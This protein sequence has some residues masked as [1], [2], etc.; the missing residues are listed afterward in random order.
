MRT[1]TRAALSA[2]V[3]VFLAS[4]SWSAP[5][6]IL[7]LEIESNGS[8]G[9]LYIDGMSTN[10]TSNW[11]WGNDYRF[12]QREKLVIGL[13]RAGYAGKTP[14]TRYR[15][16]FGGT[17]E[18]LPPPYN[19]FPD[20]TI[21]GSTLRLR[22][23][24]TDEVWA[25]DAIG[26]ATIEDGLYISSGVTSKVAT[27]TTVTNNSTLSSPNIVANWARRGFRVE[28][29]PYMELRAVAF[30]Q[31]ADDRKPVAGVEFRATDGTSSYSN[32]VTT[33]ERVSSPIWSDMPVIQAYVARFGT[34]LFANKSK[35]RVN[36]RAYALEGTNYFDTETSGWIEPSPFPTQ[37]TNFVNW[38]RTRAVVSDTGVNA[39]GVAANEEFWATNSAPAD[40]LNIGAAWLAIQG[41]NGSSYGFTN[42][43]GG[44]IYLKGLTTYLGN[45]VSG[46]SMD[47]EV[48]IT[49]HW[50]TPRDQAGIT[51]YAVDRLVNSSGGDVVRIKDCT[52]DTS[53]A[54][55]F[56]SDLRCLTMDQVYWK[57]STG[58]RVF[59]GGTVYH[60]TDCE[61]SNTYGG[62]RAYS[63][64]ANCFGLVA[65]NRIV[66]DAKALVFYTALG[67][68]KVSTNAFAVSDY[69]AATNMARGGP[70]ILAYNRF[71]SQDVS[72]LD[73]GTQQLNPCT[74]GMAVVQNELYE[75]AG[76][77]PAT[78]GAALF[79]T[80]DVASTN[81]MFWANRAGVAKLNTGY[82]NIGTNANP[83]VQWQVLN[84]I[85]DSMPIK[86][87]AF[88][89]ASAGRTGNRTVMHGVNWSG[90]MHIM[91]TNIA[92]FSDQLFPGIFTSFGKDSPTNWAK[93]TRMGGWDGVSWN[94]PFG[95]YRLR[96]SSPV[97]P[98]V[99]VLRQPLPYD[100]AGVPRGRA[101]PPGA[102]AN[103][104][105]RTTALMAQ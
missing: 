72:F 22:F 104:P 64:D 87:W 47:G 94:P 40:F 44:I 88:G 84:G 59:G 25:G 50:N 70:R 31:S 36:F 21:S 17:N 86:G 83:R 4:Q 23:G 103:T 92:D 89:T 56:S 7:G 55:L 93:W 100:L 102:Y 57:N 77:S 60:V 5:G 51:N 67:N 11:G 68:Y 28:D 99:R 97:L 30:H 58:A 41:T 49:R 90:N 29:G 76:T 42:A 10:G 33:M 38:P 12:S 15:T 35:V 69:G 18:T 95:N 80:D 8:F 98:R 96:S 65:G 101:D 1:L 24:L 48:L 52:L 91:T 27:L 61:V 9:A 54:L 26:F 85:Y 32:L 2:L 105:R 14:T 39:S 3:S 43:T 79:Q 75:F 13:S 6:D 74:F 16:I 34:N 71:P 46:N 78:Y 63:T 82:D 20:T 37:M 81:F 62:F 66:G 53:T 45:T 73:I 19:A